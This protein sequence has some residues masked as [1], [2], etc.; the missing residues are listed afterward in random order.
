MLTNGDSAFRHRLFAV[1]AL[2]TVA[3]LSSTWLLAI[4]VQ[5]VSADLTLSRVL[6]VTAILAVAWV[7]AL[8]WLGLYDHR[9]AWSVRR[10][11]MALSKAA[12]LTILCGLALGT[13][14]GAPSSLLLAILSVPL[15]LAGAGI[16]A[17]LGIRALGERSR[18]ARARRYVLVVGAGEVA[19][20]FARRITERWWLGIEVIGFLGDAA[21]PEGVPGEAYLG[22]VDDL[23]RILHE[24]VVDDVAVCLEPGDPAIEW[25]VA[26]ARDEGKTLYVPLGVGPIDAAAAGLENLDG[27]ALV[28]VVSGRNQSLAILA[29]DFVDIAGAVVGLVVLSPILAAAAIAILVSDGRPIL[30]MQPRAGL[31]GRPFRIVKFRTMTRD[32]DAQRDALRAQ[33]EI[34]GSASFK[35]TDDPRVTR[36]GRVLRKTS[37][38]ELPQLWN[39]L[40]GEMSL[41]GPRP[42]PFDDVAGYEP[43]HRRR[44]SVKPGITG[45]WQVK[46]RLDPTFDHWVQLDLE[47][48]DR[49]SLWLD[50]RLLLQTVPALLKAEGR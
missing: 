12:G 28:S 24:R 26:A 19:S 10:D 22:T 2:L 46:G 39:V 11:A 33:N 50:F 49:W 25:V 48:I 30:F 18:G 45:L 6:L 32:A 4:A 42:H 40:R 29:K 38:D 7:A 31:N 23:T 41:V 9:R 34:S 13:V 8:A 14:T 27:M 47:Y 3:I 21:I 37:I 16:A 20:D 15:L 35:L 36:V 5:E 44:L 43:W 1:D 17:R